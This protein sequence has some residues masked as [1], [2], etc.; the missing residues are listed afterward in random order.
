MCITLFFF[1]IFF[2]SRMPSN[3]DFYGTSPEEDFHQQRY[4]HSPP[5]GHRPYDDGNMTVSDK[6]LYLS[7]K[8]KLAKPFF[9][10]KVFEGNWKNS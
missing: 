5:P 4:S 8:I 1:L 3:L 10:N 2:Y 7:I 6:I 9:F